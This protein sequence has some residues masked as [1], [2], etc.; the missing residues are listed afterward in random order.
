MAGKRRKPSV[1]VMRAVTENRLASVALV[2]FLTLALLLIAASMVFHRAIPQ[3]TQ[4]VLGDVTAVVSTT[5][6]AAFGA[7]TANNIWGS[8]Y[9]GGVGI[10]VGVSVPLDQGTIP[11][12]EGV[13]TQNQSMGTPPQG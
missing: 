9:G 4:A 6:L 11:A 13:Q 12:T 1:D 3:G 7:Y 5:I 8:G 10:G 2:A